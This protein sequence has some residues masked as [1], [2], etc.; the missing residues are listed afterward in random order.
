PLF[1][2]EGEAIL[3]DQLVEHLSHRGGCI[4]AALGLAVIGIDSVACREQ[5]AGNAL[6]HQPKADDS[7]RH[8]FWQCSRH[9]AYHSIT[10]RTGAPDV[11]LTGSGRAM[12]R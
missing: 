10:A 9:G 1:P 7:N 12:R 2:S 6:A 4:G 3:F 5:A 8:I 11:P